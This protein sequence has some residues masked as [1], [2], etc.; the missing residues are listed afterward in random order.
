MT[1]EPCRVAKVGRSQTRS[2]KPSASPREG[3][4]EVLRLVNSVY[5]ARDYL[6]I[7][8]TTLGRAPAIDGKRIIGHKLIT[9]DGEDYGMIKVRFG[10]DGSYVV[11]SLRNV[12][13]VACK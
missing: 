12:S 5:I 13:I 3:S 8:I 2:A 10:S 7:L 9:S 11:V 1:M 4:W 6:W